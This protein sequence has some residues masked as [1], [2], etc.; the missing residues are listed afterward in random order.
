MD[1]DFRACMLHGGIEKIT[2][3]SVVTN[4]NKLIYD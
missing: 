4:N 2:F 3:Q 1:Y